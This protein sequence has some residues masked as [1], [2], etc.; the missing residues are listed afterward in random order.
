[1][2]KKKASK[3][4]TKSPA[5]KGLAHA[6]KK[7]ARDLETASTNS[8][9]S[10]SEATSNGESKR[11]L[12]RSIQS[13]YKEDSTKFHGRDE[14]DVME[15]LENYESLC[16]LSDSTEELMA[17][18]F[19][20]VICDAAKDFYRMMESDK[21]REWNK[22]KE[23][24][25]RRFASAA[26]RQRLT[27]KYQNLKQKT[28]YGLDAF[29][30]ELMNVSRQLP[31]EYRAPA[32]LRDKFI[33]GLH[34]SIRKAVTLVDPPSLEAA[35]DRAKLAMQTEDSTSGGQRN[36]QGR[37]P[38]RSGTRLDRNRGNRGMVGSI[39]NPRGGQRRI[40]CY[41]C[42]EEGHTKYQCSKPPKCYSC[43]KSGHLS[44]DCRNKKKEEAK[45]KNDPKNE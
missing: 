20:F 36:S 5:G 11:Q 25:Q 1:M 9:M 45:D 17:R 40:S 43:G 44:R 33:G 27:H 24:F 7:V 3:K 16:L 34:P 22:T 41:N 12:F 14:E 8:T 35:Y 18:M 23:E 38:W 28:P 37:A 2:G 6:A 29:Y 26:R 39:T 21:K 31:E 42:G 19:Q 15:F 32:M 10:G 4:S 13:Y 30:K